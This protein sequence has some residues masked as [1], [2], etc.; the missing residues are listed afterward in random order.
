MTEQAVASLLTTWMRAYIA[1]QHAESETEQ[2]QSREEWLAAISEVSGEIWRLLFAPVHEYLKGRGLR[3]LILLPQSRLQLLPLHAAWRL[4]NG[5]RRYLLDDYE[6]SY[7]PSARMEMLCQ[8]RLQ[9]P[10]S[11]GSLVVG[12]D[13]YRQLPSLSHAVAEAQVVAGFLETLPVVD[14]AAHK[15]VVLREIGGKGHLHFA[16]HGR[17]GWQGQPLASALYVAE[18]EAL[19]LDELISTRDLQGTRLVALSA[20]ESGIAALTASPDEYVGLA[21]GFLLLG[22]AGILSSLWLVDDRSTFLLMER[23]YHN[24]VTQKLPPAAA[25]REAQCWM[26]DTTRQELGDYLKS[27]TG[28]EPGKAATAY[29]DMAL[30][31]DPCEKP[32]VHPFYWA[33]FTFTGA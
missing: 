23:F 5:E 7:A 24:H 31:G 1:L 17:Y 26:R 6:V 19:S 22:A 14:D 13:S 9:A 12:V 16:C 2:A 30:G 27:L 29:M 3:R 11:S 10:Q 25:L 33:A 28:M 32:Y 20:C 4:E 18:D 8:E 21:A 15:E